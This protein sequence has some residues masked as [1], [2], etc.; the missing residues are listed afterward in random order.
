MAPIFEA[1][2]A[3]FEP[4]IRFGK[5]DTDAEGD[6]AQYFRVQTIPTLS[7]I[8]DQWEIARVAGLMTTRDLRR[9][10]YEALSETPPE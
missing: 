9:W 1:L 6:L 4:L 5:V 10:L 7:F 8:R 2:A 3:E